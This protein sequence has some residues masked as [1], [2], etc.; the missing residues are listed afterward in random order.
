MNTTIIIIIIIV[1]V[2]VVVVVVVICKHSHVI[3]YIEP[4][5]S[6]NLP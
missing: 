5:I 4:S 3:Y 1:V 6:E 2:V